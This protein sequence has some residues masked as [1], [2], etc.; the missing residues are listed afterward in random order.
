MF[1]RLTKS[2]WQTPALLKMLKKINFI[3]DSLYTI[4]YDEIDTKKKRLDV[5]YTLNLIK[6]L[7]PDVDK[8]T[9]LINQH[10]IKCRLIFGKFDDL[11]PLPAAGNFIGK[12][13]KVQVDEVY[14]GH[15]LVTPALDEYLVK[16]RS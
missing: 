1:G 11:F 7:K 12:L 9:A 14:L 10:N 4:A 13:N 5:Y 8:V 15:W 2:K 16:N 3:D 6:Q